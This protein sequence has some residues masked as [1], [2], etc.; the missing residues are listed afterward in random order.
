[1]PNKEF[2]SLLGNLNC[3]AGTLVK[4]KREVDKTDDFVKSHK[5]VSF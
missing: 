4:R 3:G 5:T 1:M 2:Y